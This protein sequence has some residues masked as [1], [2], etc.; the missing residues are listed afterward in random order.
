MSGATVHGLCVGYHGRV[1]LQG[2]TG[3]FAAGALT[4]VIG[5][6]GAGKSSLLA[7][8][9]GLR[10]FQG[11]IERPPAA[12]VAYLPQLPSLDAAVPCS[13]AE[14]VAMGL[15]PRL[16]TLR[17]LDPDG[18][19]RVARAMEAAGIAPLAR[20]L[21]GELSVGERQRVLFARI[22]VQDAALILLDEPFSAVDPATTADLMSVLRRWRGEGRTLVVVLHDLDLVRA[23][24][25]DVLLLSHGTAEWGPAARVLRSCNLQRAWGVPLLRGTRPLSLEC[26]A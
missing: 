14:V 3:E 9:A 23:Q 16:R 22:L 6:N 5:P 4:A 17:A 2:L 8:L 11:R 7:A 24:F 20:R 21:L 15:W 10:D 19:E 26:G 18:R 12:Q 25:D 1:A 13:V